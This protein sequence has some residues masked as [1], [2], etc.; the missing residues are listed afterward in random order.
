[1][2]GWRRAPDERGFTLVEV[3][4]SITLTSI[5]LGA[6]SSFFASTIRL[7]HLQEG[8]QTAVAVATEAMEAVRKLEPAS[9]VIGRDQQ[10]VDTQWANPVAGV[11]LSGMQKVYDASASSGTGGSANLPTTSQTVTLDGVA[12]QKY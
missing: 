8:R 12:Y 3:V 5:V 4:V 7:T 9:L 1:M 2:R 6:L 10:S 11:S